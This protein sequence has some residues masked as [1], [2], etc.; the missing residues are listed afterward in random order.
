MSRALVIVCKDCGEAMAAYD[1]Q[2]SDLKTLGQAVR[3]ADQSGNTVALRPSPITI[4]LG[5]CACEK[6]QTDFL[7]AKSL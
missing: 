3:A 1:P 2:R 6:P 7:N 5:S 4:Y